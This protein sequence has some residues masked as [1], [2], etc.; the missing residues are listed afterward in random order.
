MTVSPIDIKASNINLNLIDVVDISEIKRLVSQ[1]TEEE[2]LENTSRQ[3]SF[4]NHS[5]TQTYFLVDYF[6]GWEKNTSYEAKVLR[7]E[8]LIWKEIAPIVEKLEKYHD[9]KVGRVIIPKLLAGGIIDAHTD[10]GDYLESVHRH[11]IAIVTNEDV[12]F[13]VG[14]EII[15]MFAGEIWEINNNMLHEVENMSDQDRIHLL[16]DI[17]PNKYLG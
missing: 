12:F 13:R 6:L 3:T 16:I 14:D 15:N 17:I 1:L 2:W 7:P 10:G 5:T 8:S 4:K 11:H 9:G